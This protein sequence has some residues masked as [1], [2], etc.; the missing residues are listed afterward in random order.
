MLKEGIKKKIHILGELGQKK[1]GMV[2]KQ[3]ICL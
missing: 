3:N 1:V 2:P